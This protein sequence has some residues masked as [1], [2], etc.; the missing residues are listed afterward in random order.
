MD[1]PI[2]PADA[3]TGGGR[4]AFDPLGQIVGLVQV[5]L[6]TDGTTSIYGF[7][8][9]RQLTKI[10]TSQKRDYRGLTGYG[11]AIKT[12]PCCYP[13]FRRPFN[14][15]DDENGHGRLYRFELH[16]ELFLECL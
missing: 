8:V 9:I 11:S 4:S 13:I 14:V 2:T 10:L 15:V 5:D 12:T 6:S 16:P 3:C 1:L 7:A